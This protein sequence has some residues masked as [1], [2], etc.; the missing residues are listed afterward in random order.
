MLKEF[1]ES[2]IINILTLFGWAIIWLIGA[3]IL[4]LTGVGNLFQIIWLI[5]CYKTFKKT[6]KD[7]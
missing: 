2:F 5:F 3:A 6:K 7:K 4:S 1:L